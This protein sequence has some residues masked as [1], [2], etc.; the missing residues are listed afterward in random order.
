MVL[1][2]NISKIWS[3]ANLTG[4]RPACAVKCLPNEIF[5][6]LNVKPIQPGR[7]EFHRGEAYLTGVKYFAEIEL[8]QLRSA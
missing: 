6:L 4:A 5:T 3:V 8:A 2:L 1:G 7:S